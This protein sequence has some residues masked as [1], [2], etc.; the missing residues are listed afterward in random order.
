LGH[1]GAGPDPYARGPGVPGGARRGRRPRRER[2][3]A[4]ARAAHPPALRRGRG[5]GRALARERPARPFVM[6]REEVDT[7]SMEAEAE[8]GELVRRFE[9]CTLEPGAWTHEAHL[10][11]A[12]AYVR[13]H[14]P[15][16]ALGLMRDGIRRFNAFLG[17]DPAA[18]HETITRA[19]IT[20]VAGLE[21]AS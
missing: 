1:H 5:R 11:V 9:A 19:W 8:L 10:R 20:L 13:R 21:A 16:A 14:G 7:M 15:G 2:A 17:G 4:R 12:L 6:T 18:Y 3:R